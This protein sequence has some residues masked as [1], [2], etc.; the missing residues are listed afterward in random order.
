MVSPGVKPEETPDRPVIEAQRA[1]LAAALP[2]FPTIRSMAYIRTD[3]IRFVSQPALPGQGGH[4]SYPVLTV[5]SRGG[6]DFMPG[7]R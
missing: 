2:A 6:C 1:Q 4:S 3:G 7:P 5:F